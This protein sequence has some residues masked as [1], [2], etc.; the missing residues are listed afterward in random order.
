MT[1]NVV[2]WCYRRRQVHASDGQHPLRRWCAGGA[3]FRHL[4]H[5]LSVLNRI[6]LRH[7]ARPGIT[8][9]EQVVGRSALSWDDKFKRDVSYADNK[10]LLVGHQNSVADSAQGFGALEHQ[11]TL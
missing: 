9:G 3:P 7:D 2:F 11:R 10:S 4:E 1:R 5:R 6:G 8:G